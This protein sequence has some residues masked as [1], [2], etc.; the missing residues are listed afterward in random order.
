MGA[1]ARTPNAGQQYA[2]AKAQGL[3][4]VVL[5]PFNLAA[6]TTGRSGDE[7]LAEREA[8]RENI[9]RSNKTGHHTRLN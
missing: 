5:K 8:V 2:R 9:E 3:T 7:T 4:G 1:H 6:T